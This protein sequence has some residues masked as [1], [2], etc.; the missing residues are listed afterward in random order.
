MALVFQYGSNT[1][2]A[3]L[4]SS[5]RLEG[6]AV[7]LGLA[8]TEDKFGL[9]FTR[10]SQGNECAAADL[11]PDGSRRIY[12]VLYEIPDDRVF[13]SE[14]P[15]WRTL[16]DIEGEGYAYR[17]TTIRVAAVQGEPCE[18]WT[19]LV[20]DPQK[21]LKTAVHYVR[22]IIAGLREH[23]APDEYI[24]YVKERVMDNHPEIAAGVNKL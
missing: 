21:D 16:D 13:R 8:L 14:S 5:K 19:Y 22:H 17:R 4:N 9:A 15:G 2:S 1:S 7:S 24:L 20:K 10:W 6:A 12:G 18:A 23:F 11:T 3:R